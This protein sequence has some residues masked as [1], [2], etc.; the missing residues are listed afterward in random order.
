MEHNSPSLRYQ[1]IAW[2]LGETR[3]A[4]DAQSR[5]GRQI[6]KPMWG[7]QRREECMDA[8]ELSSIVP[9]SNLIPAQILLG[10]L[11]RIHNQTDGIQV[12]R[13]NNTTSG[14]WC[15]SMGVHSLSSSVKTV[16][17]WQHRFWFWLWIPINP[18]SM[19]GAPIQ[20][21]TWLSLDA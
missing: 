21:K 19:P 6:W 9:D 10:I 18:I 7:Q 3:Y 2:E 20:I 14:T 17:Q 15:S 5:L 11:P 8:S 16:R 13:G 12:G 4:T 1:V